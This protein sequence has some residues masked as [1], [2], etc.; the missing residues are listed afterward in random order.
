MSLDILIVEDEFLIALDLQMEVEAL[1]HVVL[2]PARDGES[3]RAVLSETR[4]DMAFMDIRLAGG[5]SGIDV[6]KWLY[7][8]HGVRCIFMSGNLD[9]QVMDAAAEFEPYGFLGKPVFMN[10]VGPLL[11]YVQTTIDAR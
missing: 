10:Q 8:T 4:P 7:D 9:Q 3:A 5:D 11:D 1:G 2:G 6:A